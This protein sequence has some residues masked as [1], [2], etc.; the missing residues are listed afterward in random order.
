M[1]GINPK[2]L[3]GWVGVGF[4]FVLLLPVF[5][6]QLFRQGLVP[7]DG[8]LLRLFH[9]SWAIG[10]ALLK[11]GLLGLWDPFRNMGQP[12][13]ADP[14]NQALYP[15][16]FLFYGMSFQ[17]TLRGSV[18]FH[19]GLMAFFG[20][21]MGR[22]QGILSGMFLGG[23][24]AFNGFALNKVPNPA[25]LAAMAWVPPVLYFFRKRHIWAAG[26]CIALQWMAG[27]PPY[28]LLTVL[29]TLSFLW[30]EDGSK[31]GFRFWAQA[32]ALGLGLSAVQWVPFLEMLMDSERSLFLNSSAAI[33]YSVPPKEM[34][35]S[36]ILPAVTV[37][38]GGTSSPIDPVVGWFFIGPLT[39]GLFILGVRRGGRSARWLAGAAMAGF[40]LS[41]GMANG[42]YHRIPLITVFRFPSH[43]LLFGTPCLLWVAHQGWAT[44]G[45]RSVRWIIA[46]L[47]LVDFASYAQF[48][49][50][51]WTEAKIFDLPQG[52]SLVRT[53]P[54]SE[55]VF[56]PSF[57]LTNIPNWQVKTMDDWVMIIAGSIPS[58]V[59]GLGGREVESFTVLTSRQARAYVERMNAVSFENPLFDWANVRSAVTLSVEAKDRAIPHETDFLVL[60]NPNPAGRAFM[61]NGTSV[62]PTQD[63][64]GRF[65]AQVVGPGRLV[66][67]EAFHRGWRVS[68]NGRRQW[69]EPFEKFFLSV[70][71][72]AGD[73]IIRFDFRPFSFMLGLFLTGGV[74]VGLLIGTAWKFLKWKGRRVFSRMYA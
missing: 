69:A 64:P 20:F 51:F 1:T 66:F 47:V 2:R 61:A 12:F 38:R 54:T 59:A 17:N 48:P 31:N 7:V 11:E 8:N 23:L 71:L 41:L 18:V 50:V 57:I 36:L 45:S 33:V 60:E 53:V 72:S 29:L 44:L 6:P 34:I 40:F 70:P 13:L 5:H 74:V 63:R 15:L 3:L 43:W 42:F 30:A 73:Q 49:R 67:S 58:I 21:L 26:L 56:H 4:L 25:Y 16:R 9:P 65:D 14:Q 46:V 68:V 24:F 28:F 22:R 39:L 37:F 19:S 32:Y 52:R 10:Q 35:R 55:R 27:Y 62:R